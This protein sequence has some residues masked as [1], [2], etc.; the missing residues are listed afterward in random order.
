MDF[1]PSEKV[2]ELRARVDTFMEEHIYPLELE[3]GHWTEDPANEWTYPPWF[4]GLKD[5][6]KEAGIWNWFLPKDYEDFSPGLSNLEFAPLMERVCMVPWAQEVFNCSA[7]DRGNMEVLARFGNEAQQ[8]KWLKPL[9][10]GE[11]RSAFSMTEPAV[12]SS[13]ASNLETTIV[14]DGDEYVINGRKWFTS[15]AFNPLCRILVVMGKTNPDA[16][17]HRQFSMIL[18]PLDTPGVNL[19]RPLRAFGG[20]HSPG[21]HAQVLYDNVRVPVENLI[22]GEGRGFEIAQGRLGPGRFQYAMMFVGMAQRC[23]DLMCKRVDSRVAF[24]EKLADK[25]SIQHDVARSRYE[26]EQCRLLVLAAADKMDKFGPKGARD[27]ISMIK[28]AAPAMCQAVADRAIQAHGGMGVTQD[29]PLARIYLTS[30]YCRIA[31]GPD[32]VHMS[33]LGRRTIRDTVG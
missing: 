11:I 27:Y 18:V 13:D 32:E 26:I 12:A 29:T 31:D 6:A 7:P 21:G 9:L 4:E 25:T 17:R 33:Q 15:N 28:V 10:N 22:L 30:R 23:L 2:L 8:E 5:K 24:G 3:H 14:R 16:A 20:V 19:E 1:E